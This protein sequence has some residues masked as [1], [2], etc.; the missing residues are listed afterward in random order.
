[1]TAPRRSLVRLNS[2]SSASSTALIGV[3]EGQAQE[4]NSALKEGPRLKEGCN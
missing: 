2:L 1:M 4:E 3:N